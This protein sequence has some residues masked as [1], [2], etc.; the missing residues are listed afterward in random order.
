MQERDAS[1]GE[2]E[3]EQK[4]PYTSSERVT[5]SKLECELDPFYYTNSGFLSL[6]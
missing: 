4:Y 3:N 6:I 1:P 2:R 5:D